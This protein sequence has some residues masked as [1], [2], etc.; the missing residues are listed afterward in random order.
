MKQNK[1]LGTAYSLQPIGYN[2]GFV[3][4]KFSMG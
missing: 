2:Y 1:L 3:K 4:C